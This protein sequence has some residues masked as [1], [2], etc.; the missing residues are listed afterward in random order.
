MSGSPVTESDND[1]FWSIPA[2]DLRLV[3]KIA[4]GAGGQV[5]SARYR[6][7][8]PVAAKEMYSTKSTLTTNV[9]P[10]AELAHECAVLGQLHHIN[11]VAFLGLCFMPAT[12]NT[13]GRTFIV[14]E[15]C[16]RNLRT[17]MEDAHADHHT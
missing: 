9:A 13:P 1:V 7:N 3:E 6:D 12:H 17:C 4:A 2:T 16:A 8:T 11:I 5:W 14:Q 15:F 10:P